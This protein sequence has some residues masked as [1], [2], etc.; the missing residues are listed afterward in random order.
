MFVGSSSA[1]M[2]DEERIKVQDKYK[3]NLLSLLVA[4]KA[5]GMGIDK[6]NIRYTIHLGIPSSI[7]SLYQE[8]GR[9]GRD[10]KKS[11][12]YII[13]AKPKVSETEYNEMFKSSANY[14]EIMNVLGKFGYHKR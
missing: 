2:T 4:T 9:A 1:E 5:F 13:H 11:I 12:C 10:R 8:I 14:C 7:E 3:N 6:D